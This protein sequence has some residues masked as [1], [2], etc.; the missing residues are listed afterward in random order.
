MTSPAGPPGPR[1]WMI[2]VDVFHLAGRGTVVTGRLE[3]DQQLGVGYTAICDGQRWPVS[4]ISQLQVS[5]LSADPGTEVGVLLRDGPPSEVLRG[6]VIWFE[7]VVPQ[8][9]Q[10]RWKSVGR[11][12][13]PGRR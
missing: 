12:K 7:P 1:I 13:R 11:T 3:G 9:P 2:A 10:P 5:R 6:K 8:D 4:Q